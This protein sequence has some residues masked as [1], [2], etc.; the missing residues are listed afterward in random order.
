MLARL[1]AGDDHFVTTAWALRRGELVAVHD[2]TTRVS[3]RRADDAELEACLD[4]GDFADKA[5]AYAI[6]GAAAAL[7]S[8]IEGSYTNV[9]GLPL[10]Q[11]V[12]ALRRLAR[13]GAP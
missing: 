9:V 4:A 2:E 12:E 5:G 1:T 11:V 7:V 6:Q 3:M 13:E 10:A 8:R